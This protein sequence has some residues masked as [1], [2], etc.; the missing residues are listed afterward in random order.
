MAWNASSQLE[1]ALVV[2]NTYVASQEF[3]GKVA[4]AKALRRAALSPAALV[5]R[6][7][8]SATRILDAERMPADHRSDDV[9]GTFKRPVDEREG[10]Q[11]DAPPKGEG[12]YFVA[13]YATACRRPMD[14]R[15]R[16]RSRRQRSFTR[17]SARSSP[18]AG[19]Q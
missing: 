12:T 7:T 2:Q 15:Y 18:E 8:A 13:E 11:A 1:R 10:F 17:R 3:N 4:E 16:E 9:R 5:D 19:V 14:R 6:D